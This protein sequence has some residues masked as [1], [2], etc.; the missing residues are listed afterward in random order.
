M[1]VKSALMT[2]ARNHASTNA[3]RGGVFAQGAGFVRPTPRSIRASCSTT[4]SGP[5]SATSRKWSDQD[6]D[7]VFHGRF[8]RTS[9]SQLNQASIAIGRLA[10]TETV[11]RP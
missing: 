2:T 4:D 6:L 7:G 9:G 10:G 3:R 11:T 8:R 1:E 5:G